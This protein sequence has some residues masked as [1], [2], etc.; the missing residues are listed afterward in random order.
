M[1]DRLSHSPDEEPVRPNKPKSDIPSEPKQEVT[2]HQY[3][4][5]AEAK[6]RDREMKE[7]EQKVT[8]EVLEQT[9]GDWVPF[10]SPGSYVPFG[11]VFPSKNKNTFKSEEP[12]GMKGD[13]VPFSSPGSYIPFGG[14]FSKWFS[15]KEKNN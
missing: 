15:R 6:D 11:G 8:P 1:V 10:S 4:P 2:A 7:L 13:W 3:D 9:R 5:S 14:V 12:K